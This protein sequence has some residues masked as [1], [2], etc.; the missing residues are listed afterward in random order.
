MVD[1]FVTSGDEVI[2][3][4]AAVRAAG[5]KVVDAVA[6]VDGEIGGRERLAEEGIEL[7]AMVKVSEVVRV[8]K[9]NGRVSEEVER[10]VVEFLRENHNRK[11]VFDADDVEAADALLDV[12][13]KV[14]VLSYLS[15]LVCFGRFENLSSFENMFK[16]ISF[17]S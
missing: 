2:E 17:M 3:A 4:A 7:H 1:N 13:D 12:G 10:A 14:R 15:A 5:M 6:V 9:E 11:E 16:L 8:L